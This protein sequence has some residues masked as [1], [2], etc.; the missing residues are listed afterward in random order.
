[1]SVA[2]Y[3]NKFEELCRI[4]RVCQGDPETYESWGCVKY[5]RGLK[6]N[7]M[8]DVAPMEIRVFSDLVNK[9]RVVEE[10]A[11]T[12]ATS[13]D[14]HGGSSSLGR[15]KYFHPRGPS[16]KRGG[17][18][19]LGGCFKCG[20]P[21]HIARDCPRGRNQN[22]G[23]SQHQGRVFA[24]NAKDTSKADSSM[25]GICLIGDKSLV[26]LYDTGASH[27]FISFAKVEELG[28]KLSE[29]P[30]DLHMILWFDWLSKNRV[31]LDCFEWTIRFMPKGENGA[32]NLDQI[33]VVRD[34]PEVFLEDIPEFPP[35][36]E[37]EFA[38]EL[39]PGAGP[40]RVKEDDIP[41]IAFRTRFGHYEFATEK[42]HEKH[43]KIV[44]KILKERKLYA[45]LSKCEFWKE[46]V[47]FLGHVVSKGGI[48]VDP[49]KVEAVMEWERPT[50]VMEVRHFLGLAG[51]YQRF[52]EGFSRIALPMTK[53]TRKEVPFGW[54]LE[55]EESFQ[56]L[57]HRLT[58]API[59]ILP[60][61]HEPV[62]FSVFSDHKSLKY[63]FDQKELN[64]RQRRWMELLKDYD[65]ELSYHPGK[66]TVV[67]DALS[68][69]S[70]T[71]AWKF[72]DLK[73]DID[74]V[75]GRA[76]L[77]QLQISSTFKSEIQRTQQDEQKLQ[78]CFNQLVIGGAKNSLRMMKGCGDTNEEFA[79][80]M[81]G[82]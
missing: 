63:I 36:R 56:T 64:M 44:L 73:L 70:L 32:M 60:E 47:K 3:I 45:K 40:I 22:V 68:Q 74:E 57:K 59:L 2:E 27:L 14:T 6:D 10:N 37:I 75:A 7:I 9:A 49:S 67:V 26:A 79:Y 71:I 13:K 58:S 43:L 11:K 80:R 24:M 72:V 39:V 34:F 12:V 23:Q 51:Y 28:L 62:R 42:E 25:R 66:A 69:K 54:M 77:N 5:Q 82:V 19:G 81:L 76:C 50:T 46:E 30:F 29:L 17:Y 41:K 52:I 48:A 65:F 53:L 33:S 20:L 31:L 8:T 78:N 21:D 4:S 15:G 61:P 38:I 1:M 55:C 16:F 35:Q 18:I